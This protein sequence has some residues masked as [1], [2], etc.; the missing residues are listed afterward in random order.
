MTA[1]SPQPGLVTQ[2]T[3][4]GQAVTVAMPPILG[5]YVANPLSAA[6][7]G[8]ATAET[9]YVNP[10][11]PA[12]L[13]ANGATLALA[14]GAIWN[15]PGGSITGVSVNSATAGHKFSVVKW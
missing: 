11:G 8:I 4:A 15:M 3:T 5:G 9:L 13:Q 12:L 7:Q 10:C 6:D 2:I 1:V 14:P